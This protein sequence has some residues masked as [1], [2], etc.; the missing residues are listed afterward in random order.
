M[1]F[2]IAWAVM[3]LGSMALFSLIISSNVEREGLEGETGLS[4]FR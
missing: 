3:A 4:E 1:T 2:G